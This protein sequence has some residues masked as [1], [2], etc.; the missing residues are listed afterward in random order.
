MEIATEYQQMLDKV[1]GQIKKLK[2]PSLPTKTDKKD[3]E[4]RLAELNKELER[5]K[6]Y[7]AIYSRFK[8]GS[9]V[10]IR[11]EYGVIVDRVINVGGIPQAWVKGD[12]SAV[13]YPEYPSIEGHLE[14]EVI[15]ENWLHEE[16]S[17]EAA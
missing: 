9:R 8:V 2:L 10:C 14:M 3:Y 16:S 5:I 17:E 6:K 13:L 1:S 12:Y 4:E 15:S 7:A 11:G